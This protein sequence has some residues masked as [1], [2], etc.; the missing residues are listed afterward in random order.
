[1][2]DSWTV[3][4][5][6]VVHACCDNR[7]D[8]RHGV[9]DPIQESNPPRCHRSWA[10]FPSA[11]MDHDSR[12]Q[13][14]STLF[15]TANG[16]LMTLAGVLGLLLVMPPAARGSDP[17]EEFFEKAVRPILVAHCLECHGEKQTAGLF[18]SSR[19]NL[20]KG[21]ESGPAI[22]PGNPEGSLLIQAVQHRD[23]LDM[24]PETKL[25]DRDIH[26]LIHWVKLGAP[27]PKS[28]SLDLADPAERAK[29]HW[30]FQPVQEP[31][32]PEVGN[33]S[34]VR[35]PI[36][37]F[38][39]QGLERAKL[40]L[41]PEADRRTLI[42][43]LSYTLTGLPPRPEEVLAFVNDPSPDAEGRLIERLLESPQYGEH[44]ARHWLDVARYSDTKGYVY[45]RE[46]RFWV[47]AWTYRD[48]VVRAFNHDLPYDRFLLLQ[49]AA[50]QVPDRAPDDL[51]AM[52][53]LTIGRRFLG[54]KH[55]IIDDRID[56]VSRG[57]LG[58]SVGCARCHDHK[59]DPI[60]TTDYYSLYG[61]FDSSAERY[62]PLSDSTGDD[63]Y[64]TE[65][66]KRREALR[67]KLAEHRQ[68]T[69]ARV[70]QRIGDYLRAQLELEKYPAEGF[71]QVFE[72]NDLLPAFVRRWESY[73]E[74]AER[75]EDPVFLH[76]HAYRRLPAES[77]ANQAEAVTSSLMS[78]ANSNVPPLVAAA[79]AEA[80][81]SFEEVIDRY[82]TLFA[83]VDAQWKS[84]VDEAEKQGEAAPTTFSETDLEALRRVLYGPGAPC[85]VPDEPIVHSETYFH[86]GATT[87]LWKLQGELDRWIINSSVADPWALT[88]VD[89][90]V[91]VEPR[92]LRRGNPLS[93]GEHVPRQFLKIL[94][95]GDRQPFQHG[96][97]RL[98]MAR[99]IISPENPLT[100]RVIVN[101]VWAH[102]FGQGLVSTPSDFGLR[103]EE[104]SHPELLDWLTARFVAEGWS[105]KQLHRWILSSATW[106][107]SSAGPAE[108]DL[109]RQARL[110]DPA[111]RLL[112]RMNPHRLT[113]EELRDS[114]LASSGQ[115]DL[116]TGGK[117]AKLFDSPF[118]RRR[119]LYGLVDR[120]FFPGTLRV[121]DFA[122]PD[123]HIP[124]RN[125]TTVPQQALFLLNHP[126]VLEEVRALA[127]LATET[128]EESPPREAAIR[129]L[130]QRVVQ[131]DPSTS[132]LAEAIVFLSTIEEIPQPEIRPTAADWQYGYGAVDDMEQ[133]VTG[134]TPLPH[135]TGES[136]QGGA[137]WP[138]GKLG[139]VQLTAKGGHPGNDRSHAAIRRWTAPRAMTIHIHSKLTHE[140][141]PG[142]GIRAFIV[143]SRGGQLAA[144]KVHQQ[145]ADL[146]LSSLDVDAGETL[147]FVVD[148]DEVL[149]SDQY[150]WTVTIAESTTSGD[151]TAWDSVADFTVDTVR[152]LTAWEQLAHVLLLTNEFLFVE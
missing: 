69:S 143:G 15:R 72:P 37:A 2:G 55:E 86:S 34:W 22:V 7:L 112:W 50:D 13:P 78:S 127:D 97:G 79:F 131:R 56:A 129:A 99:A 58:L 84:L 35:T 31:T 130:F 82:A 96:S 100:A 144:A 135:F 125:E 47:H 77:F 57:M 64:R 113:F 88:L 67:A 116:R 12:R 92:V 137:K 25:D 132:E 68:E 146:D 3:A 124:A 105:L 54:V 89:R 142:D 6:S 87:E 61:V 148:I 85:E 16:W 106:R 98:E 73:L 109:L 111:N 103:S 81:T 71:D 75:Q 149:N 151:T 44:W 102:H 17:G 107:Q 76:W 134:F 33:S 120:Q 83:N 91:P 65:L 42:R 29:T 150:E 66:E 38:I 1:M 11:A 74:E 23:G 123:L 27:W 117:S 24:P 90:P 41:S 26:T 36:D 60:P 63:A 43:R 140:A 147:D 9:W 45:A 114:L 14:W 110:V 136:W 101:R 138:D 46:E 121:F 18:L 32:I 4:T 8:A 133:Q 104:P 30:A 115:L 126:L 70:R 52:G 108:E 21:G 94:A 19:E 145:S 20:L 40:S 139:W 80:P 28:D 141:V 48:W 51:A 128:A 59:Y 53:F 122:N 5:S 95:S 118:P 119:T 62:V 152:Q 10:S 49:L 39:L 93:K